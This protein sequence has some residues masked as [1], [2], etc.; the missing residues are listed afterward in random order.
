[1]ISRDN[2]AKS[3]TL[4][5]TIKDLEKR[6][7][8]LEERPV[9]YQRKDTFGNPTGFVYTPGQNKLHDPVELDYIKDKK[10]GDSI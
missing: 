4:E 10:I 9:L 6:I 2:W 3:L 7:K 8:K 5:K 1:M